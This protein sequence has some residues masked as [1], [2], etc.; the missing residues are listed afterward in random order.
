MW[1][2]D[3]SGLGCSFGCP[4]RCLV[5]F[6]SLES[7]ETWVSCCG[8]VGGTKDSMFVLIRRDGIHGFIHL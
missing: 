2:C 4:H 6:T 3:Q 8:R 7:L 1:V 5:K